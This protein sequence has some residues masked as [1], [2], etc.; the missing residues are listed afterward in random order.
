MKN[1]RRAIFDSLHHWPLL[2]LATLCSVGV[3]T[4]WSANIGAMYPVIQMTLKTNPFKVDWPMRQP[5]L[6]KILRSNKQP[7]RYWNVSCL[8]L[9][10]RQR[11][12]RSKRISKNWLSNMHHGTTAVLARLAIGISQT[13][14]ADGSVQ[15]HL[16]HHG[17][18][19]VQYDGQA[20]AIL[21]NDMLIGRVSTTI[22]R[23]LRRRLFDQA[24]AYDRRTY[25]GYGTSSMLASITH[26]A[27]MLSNGLISFFWCCHSRTAAR[28]GLSDWCCYC[29][30]A[31]AVVVGRYGSAVD[32]RCL[33][34]QWTCQRYRAVDARSDN[35]LP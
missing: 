24:L 19:G 8:P 10:I 27:D 17:R 25:Q 28:S 2:V 4:L 6:V 7:Q 32:P 3:A 34:V 23:T 12:S 16:L 13:D 9:K 21:A 14:V 30:L 31:T 15:N 29:V 18:V 11:L 35:W 33:L 1:F 20:L 5:T 26:T 22:A